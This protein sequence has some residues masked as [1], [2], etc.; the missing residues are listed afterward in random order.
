[1]LVRPSALW[2]AADR[3]DSAV[4]AVDNWALSTER[5]ACHFRACGRLGMHTVDALT[6]LYAATTTCLSTI[7]SPYYRLLLDTSPH[8]EKGPL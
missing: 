4:H 6:G 2:T 7:H 5:H 1:M 3:V 8:D